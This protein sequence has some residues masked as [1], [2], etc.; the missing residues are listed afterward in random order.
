[1]KNCNAFELNLACE[2]NSFAFFCMIYNFTIA[3]TRIYFAICEVR[4]RILNYYCSYYFINLAFCTG[5]L[6]DF[7]PIK[8]VRTNYQRLMGLLPI[9]YVFKNLP[10]STFTFFLTI[11]VFGAISHPLPIPHFSQKNLPPS[12]PVFHQ[13][14]SQSKTFLNMRPVPGSAIFCSNAVLITT[15]SSSMQFSSFFDLLPSAPTTTGM[16]LM[17]LMLHIILIS[18]FSSRYLLIFSFFFSLTR[19]S[20]GIAIEYQL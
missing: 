20:P 10:S 13:P 17:R 18:F 8:Q 11:S 9:S 16:T 4:I 1:M 5:N 15:P 7:L 14:Y 19:M 12:N 3:L 6:T 2:K